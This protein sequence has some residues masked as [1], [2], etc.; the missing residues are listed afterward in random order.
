M[1]SEIRF[2]CPRHRLHPG[3]MSSE[4]P[5]H[6]VSDRGTASEIRFIW[7]RP[8]APPKG[9]GVRNSKATRSVGR[10]P[11]SEIRFILSSLSQGEW[12]PKIQSH[13]IYARGNNVPKF[14]LFALGTGS[15]GEWRPKIQSH[16]IHGGTASE[17]RFTCPRHRLPGEWRP[18]IQS[19]SIHGET[20]SEIRFTCPHRLPGGNGI[21]KS[22]VTRSMGERR[23]KFG[24]LALTGSQ[25]EWRPKIQ[26]HS[27]H[28]G[29][30]SEIRFTCPHRFPGECRPKI[31][32]SQSPGGGDGVRNSV[33][34]PSPAPQ[35]GERRPKNP[36]QPPLGGGNGVRNSVS[37][38][39]SPA[40]PRGMASE[41]PGYR[42]P[43]RGMASEIRFTCPYDWPPAPPG[44]ELRPK[45]ANSL[46][47]QGERRPQF[48]LF[49]LLPPQ[50]TGNGVR[51]SLNPGGT[52]SEISKSPHPQEERRPKFAPI[53]GEW[54]P[55]STSPTRVS[56]LQFNI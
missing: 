56:T 52:A 45:I 7:H 54:R 17:I 39:L 44:G 51:N 14:G 20:A 33:Y 4:I 53:P 11:T 46:E 32:V 22:K 28:G 34:L 42:I 12:R 1:K 43:G 29:T 6:P 19:H 41:N 48:G 21:R 25:G 23:P 10:G 31:Q 26:S 3:G 9:S 37:L 40:P 24:L 35:K 8:P 30:A 55:K 38:P 47:T 27:I 36:G 15:Q 50:P 2:V 18:K 13:S 5:C 16:S 49:A